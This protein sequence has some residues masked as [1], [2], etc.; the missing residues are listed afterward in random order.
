MTTSSDQSLDQQTSS[1][2]SEFQS[3]LTGAFFDARSRSSFA[4]D[5]MPSPFVSFSETV[6]WLKSLVS[7][8][9][10]SA[11][12]KPRDLGTASAS[13]EK[14]WGPNL[15][16]SCEIIR[17]LSIVDKQECLF[18]SASLATDSEYNCSLTMDVAI[19]QG[20][21][22]FRVLLRVRRQAVRNSNRSVTGLF[23]EIDLRVVPLIFNDSGAQRDHLD[24]KGNAKEWPVDRLAAF[25]SNRQL[26]VD[27]LVI[28]GTAKSR[29][30]TTDAE[31]LADQM[32][33]VKTFR[34]L[35]K[36]PH[37]REVTVDAGTHP[38]VGPVLHVLP[39]LLICQARETRLAC[40]AAALRKIAECGFRSILLGCVDRQTVSAYYGERSDGSFVCHPN[41]HGYWSS[42]ELGIDP[43]LG[44]ETDYR[45][46][47]AE[48]RAQGISVIQD[49][50]VATLGY[51]AQL[52]ELATG[53]LKDPVSCVILGN[54]EVDVTDSKF[55]LHHHL[56]PD[57]DIQDDLCTAS[58]YSRIITHAHIAAPFALP[59]L[60]LYRSD[61]REWSL[62]RARWQTMTAG[63]KSFRLDMAKHIGLPQL[64]DIVADLRNQVAHNAAGRSE[65]GFSVLLEYWSGSYRDLRFVS[66]A[67]ATEN[68]G[69]YLFDFP[70]ASALQSLLFRNSSYIHEIDNILERRKFWKVDPRQLIPLFVDHD[71]N[72]RPMYNGSEHTRNLVVFG[73][74]L[75]IMVSAN[76]PYVYSGVFDRQNGVSEEQYLERCKLDYSELCSRNA[77]EQLF[78]FADRMSPLGPLLE[79]LRLSRDEIN[80]EHYPVESVSAYGDGDSIT[81]SRSAAKGVRR[82]R[83]EATFSRRR[84]REL[85]DAAAT[86]VFA[87]D[88]EPSVMI[89]T[90]ES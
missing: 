26:L 76:C 55:F 40:L 89:K 73:Y 81:I 14:G 32:M 16:A 15:D 70:L 18:R 77:T 13:L 5:S 78:P 7:S 59:K 74:A 56:N 21:R 49:Y 68:R 43:D 39:R 30:P 46:L 79:L 47:V 48:A 17:F 88:A 54:Q 22:G 52:K 2:V 61:V 12:R 31:I 34:R 51:P 24:G 9:R 62:M 23:P 82:R 69:V 41:N 90:Y 53:G 11:K 35:I 42:G 29:D 19:M 45:M 10:L 38:R 57:G 60:N 86:I 25:F 72:F 58:R 85:R 63:V 84:Q 50:V 6:A 44:S 71:F 4:R 8:R 80:T 67:L 65:G 3:F 20:P 33:A 64:R 75:A 83:I 66:D 27:K 36:R 1:G 87:L 37:V 28:N